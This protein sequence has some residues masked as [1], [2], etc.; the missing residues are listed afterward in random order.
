MTRPFVYIAG[1]IRTGST[2]LS[3]ALSEPGRA[4]IIREP[5]LGTNRIVLRN[6]DRQS[7]R[8]HGLDADRAL[9]LPR[10]LMRVLRAAGKG[11]HPDGGSGTGW[12][13]GYAARV[14]RDRIAGGLAERVEQVGI[15]EVRHDGWEH[16]LAAFP[17]L[18]C[19]AIARDPR[20]VYLSQ[21]ARILARGRPL[22][23]PEVFATRLD[24]QFRLQRAL[25]HATDAL[26]IRYEDLCRDS[27]VLGSVRA[28]VQSPVQG[29][30]SV[31]AFT[32][33]QPLRQPE[34]HLHGGSLTSLRVA[35]WTREPDAEALRA[36]HEVFDAM[37]EYR[38]FWG[39][40]RDPEDL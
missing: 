26:T 35:R 7:L 25:V 40:S 18:R 37:G 31:G 28:F 8:D 10:Q 1:L 14:F 34:Q 39:Y 16:V 24:R 23:S 19:V 20:D 12:L 13:S 11:G 27:A 2:A 6:A 33:S 30:G 9:A 29:A 15:K 3:E 4:L 5:R 32:A 17:G 38:A 21:C 36:A 22:P